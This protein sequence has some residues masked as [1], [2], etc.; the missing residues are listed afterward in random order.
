ML[1]MVTFTIN[2]PP[3]L[4]YI[5]Y[6]DPMGYDRR[7]CC[8]RFIWLSTSR[9]GIQAIL[10][11]LSLRRL[12]VSA[13]LIYFQSILSPKQIEQTF[14][15]IL[16]DF[17][18]LYISTFLDLFGFL[19]IFD[20]GS[21]WSH[22]RRCV[23]GVWIQNDTSLRPHFRGGALPWRGRF[24]IDR[25]GASINGVDEIGFGSIANHIYA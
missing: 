10:L 1:Y 13:T 22:G 14:T 24:N 12:V 21:I 4:A 23:I 5:P 8:P 19:P 3:M 9:H 11:C 20:L 17:A 18:F 6:M 25:C 15:I 2:I 16:M 7:W